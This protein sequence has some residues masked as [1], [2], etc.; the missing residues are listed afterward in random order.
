MP[1]CEGLSSMWKTQIS[2]PL[3]LT[4]CSGK[5]CPQNTS[6]SA[7]PRQHCTS[8][9]HQLQPLSVGRDSASI[10][11]PLQFNIVK[12]CLQRQTPNKS[13]FWN[14]CALNWDSD[15]S[16][17]ILILTSRKAEPLSII[18]NFSYLIITGM[19][20]NEMAFNFDFCRI[21]RVELH[22][23]FWN[24]SILFSKKYIPQTNQ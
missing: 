5:S 13:A 18:S 6:C 24:T 4:K 17:V 9:K 8:V 2:K 1:W 3:L 7:D 14:T 11:R 22:R 12:L 16:H 21:F 20:D 10:R 19:R 23:A 15:V